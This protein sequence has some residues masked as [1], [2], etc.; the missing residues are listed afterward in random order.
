[1]K[2]FRNDYCIFLPAFGCFTLQT[3]VEVCIFINVFCAARI[4]D[5]SLYALH[6]ALQTLDQRFG[7]NFKDPFMLL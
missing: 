6:P 1:M 7:G 2:Y 4:I 5:L 3:L